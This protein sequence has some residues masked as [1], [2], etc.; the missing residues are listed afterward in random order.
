MRMCSMDLYRKLYIS[1]IDYIHNGESRYI[2]SYTPFYNGFPLPPLLASDLFMSSY[3]G[4]I[5]PK[6][7]KEKRSVMLDLPGDGR[8][9]GRSGRIVIN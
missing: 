8:F 9:T 5:Y 1:A 7:L 3:I 6:I 4:L 2:P